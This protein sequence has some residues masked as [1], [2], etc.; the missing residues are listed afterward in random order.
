MNTPKLI[1]FLLQIS[2]FFQGSCQVTTVDIFKSI[3]SFRHIDLADITKQLTYT[4]LRDSGQSILIGK[5][6]EIAANDSYIVIYDDLTNKLLLF[7]N[8]GVFLE[9][10][11]TKGKGPNEFIGIN[12]I[13]INKSNDILVLMNSNKVVIINPLRAERE[14]FSIKGS[15]PA[16]KWLNESAIVILYPFPRFILNDGYEI[17]FI[18]RTGKILKKALPNSVKNV[19]YNDIDPRF[20]CENNLDSLYYW[21]SYRDTIYSISNDMKLTA[22]V[23]LINNSKR[24]PLDLI[25]KGAM[26]NG[27]YSSDIGY[28]Q[29][30]YHEFGTLILANLTYRRSNVCLVIDRN[31]G[32]GSNI[33]YDYSD[34]HFRGLKN[35]ID[36]GS[37][38]WPKM[39]TSSGDII[40]AIDPNNLR[41]TFLKNEKAKSSVKFPSQK[42]YLKKNIIDKISLM[43]NPIIV[44]I[45]K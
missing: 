29:N 45:K 11:M 27:S 30:S 6:E 4:R 12:S 2:I 41:E 24:Y 35:N 5:I 25:K 22:R 38:F 36:G 7:D 32:I 9:T 34:D 3:N 31:T 23:I 13:D 28:V 8:D 39:V 19:N 18:D 37:E 14:N 21:N 20:S 26:V 40:T 16:A 10:L 42:D 33:F 1:L 44:K 15:S 43:D 17:S